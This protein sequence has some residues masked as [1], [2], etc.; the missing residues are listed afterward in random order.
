MVNGMTTV[1]IISAGML[2]SGPLPIPCR[3]KVLAANSDELTM[4]SAL[5]SWCH[6]GGNPRSA[7]TSLLSLLPSL[8]FIHSIHQMDMHMLDADKLLPSITQASKNLNLGC[9]SPHQTS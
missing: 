5:R 4:P 2:N 9:I 7:S 3:A 6:R 1:V 8:A